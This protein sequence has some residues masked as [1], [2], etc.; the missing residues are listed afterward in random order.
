MAV[1]FSR[2][3]STTEVWTKDKSWGVIRIKMN[4]TEFYHQEN[5]CRQR[6][7]EVQG[8]SSGILQKTWG[9]DTSK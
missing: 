9:E 3:K 6:K 7:E 5:E 1:G 2:L 4:E 8:L